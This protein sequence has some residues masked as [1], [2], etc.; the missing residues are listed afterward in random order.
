MRPRHR[1]PRSIFA[2]VLAVVAV[3]ASTLVVPHAVPASAADDGL[4]LEA[5]SARPDLVTA[6]DALVT[7]SVSRDK[8]LDEV[9]ISL[10]GADVTSSFRADADAHALTGLVDQLGPGQNHLVA[11]A[12]SLRDQLALTNHP[13]TGPVISGPHETPYV[14]T[15]ERFRLV[16]GSTLGA[17]LD[18]DCSVATR[19]DY[20]YRS[21][22]GTTKPLPDPGT[23]DRKSV[24]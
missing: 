17:P 8:P 19:V 9:R 3:T 16:D 4:R 23:R 20:A 6:D 11:T 21:T 14:C 22:A 2:A 15:T 7:A 18:A 24:V 5:L 13:A 10:N 12:G 1:P